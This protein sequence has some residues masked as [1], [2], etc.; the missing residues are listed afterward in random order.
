MYSYNALAPST[1]HACQLVFKSYFILIFW[2]F[3]THLSVF[4]SL[5]SLSHPLSIN[6]YYISL[7]S[8]SPSLSTPLSLCSPMSVDLKAQSNS[9][10]A[11][12]T[13]N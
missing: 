12:S 9:V 6:P 7:G 10:N 4:I 3:L 11:R 13:Q 2:H 1:Q 5:F 8:H